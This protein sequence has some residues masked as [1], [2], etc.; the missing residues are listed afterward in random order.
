MTGVEK[1]EAP[2]YGLRR[3][4][5]LVL[6]VAYASNIGGVGTLFGSSPNV[7]LTGQLR[8]TFGQTLSFVDY[9]RIG[10]PLVVVLLP[11]TWLVLVWMDR[12]RIRL[13]I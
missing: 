12:R 4:V 8:Q 2:G 7:V 13:S 1:S 5:C 11:L 3:G 10:V 9:A 6:A